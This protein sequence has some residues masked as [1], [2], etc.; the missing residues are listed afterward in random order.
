MYYLRMYKYVKSRKCAVC[1]CRVSHK[2]TFAKHNHQQLTLY[3]QLHS[4]TKQKQISKLDWICEKYMQMSHNN[5]PKD[6]NLQKYLLSLD[7]ITK[8]Q[9][10]HTSTCIQALG[11]KGYVFKKDIVN[12]YKIDMSKH[13]HMEDLK[14]HT[15][16]FDNYMNYQI[17]KQKN[18]GTHLGIDSEGISV[19]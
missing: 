5:I 13:C 8:L 12:L 18:I 6:S 17:K 10:Q 3:T 14:A 1:E 11:S 9:A 7:P 19:R 16:E 15:K 2:W 4:D